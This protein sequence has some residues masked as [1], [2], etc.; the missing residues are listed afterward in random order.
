MADKEDKKAVA[1]KTAKKPAKA[2]GKPSVFKRIGTWFKS[3]NSE[4]K[5]ISWATWK[6]VR[7]NTLIV[8]VVVV[9][10]AVAIGIVDYLLTQGIVGLSRIF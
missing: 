8:I 2:S 4:R 10:L 9:V 6:S 3:L 7:K 5:K 1:E